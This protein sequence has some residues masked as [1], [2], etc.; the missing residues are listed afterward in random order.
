MKRVIRAW[1]AMM[2]SVISFEFIGSLLHWWRRCI[3]S[4]CLLHKLPCRVI[5]LNAVL[6]EQQAKR[7]G[8]RFGFQ[9]DHVGEFGQC[10]PSIDGGVELARLL[11]LNYRSK[12][13][14]RTRSH[15][16]LVDRATRNEF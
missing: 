1:N 14:R 8:H 6:F 16:A 15:R 2:R 12:S 13:K 3:A 4:Q 7:P 9:G 11:I 10:S 5:H